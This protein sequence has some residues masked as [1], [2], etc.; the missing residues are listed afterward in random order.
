M[1][2]KRGSKLNPSDLNS[3]A[4]QVSSSNLN[5]VASSAALTQTSEQLLYRN[6]KDII[7]C[8][9]ISQPDLTKNFY[10]LKQV[11]FLPGGLYQDMAG[12]FAGFGFE[13]NGN[14]LVQFNIVKECFL[15]SAMVDGLNYLFRH[16]CKR[17]GGSLNVGPV[18]P[19]L[20]TGVGAPS[21]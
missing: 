12:G 15:M 8:R 7:W 20:P 3:I 4:Q 11:E 9:V 21:V 6:A 18:G 17:T 14:I 5:T 19:P 10:Y 1:N 13:L 2:I 16:C